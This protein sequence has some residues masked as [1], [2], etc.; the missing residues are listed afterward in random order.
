MCLTRKPHL[1]VVCFPPSGSCRIELEG[2][3]HLR[4]LWF[5]LNPALQIVSDRTGGVRMLAN[6]GTVGRRSTPGVASG[7]PADLVGPSKCVQHCFGY[8]PPHSHTSGASSWKPEAL[9]STDACPSGLKAAPRLDGWPWSTS[10]SNSFR[11]TSSSFNILRWTRLASKPEGV[12]F[13]V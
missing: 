12:C 5:S 7:A 4:F 8:E 11:S 1:F 6:F 13:G 9:M 10:S 3:G 2:S